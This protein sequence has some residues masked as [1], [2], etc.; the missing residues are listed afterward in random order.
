MNPY[1]D[2]ATGKKLAGANFGGEIGS[3]G[4]PDGN[5]NP[6]RQYQAVEFEINKGLGRNWAIV[7]NY[8]IARLIGNYEGA[9]RNDNG[10][11]DPGISSLF[12]FTPGKLNMLGK[13]MA[14]GP[15][16]TDRRHVLNV[17]PTVI[18]P[19]GMFKNLVLGSR[20]NIQSGVPLM[21]LAANMAYTNQGEAVPFGRGD[22]GRAPV[23]GTVDAHVE[24]PWKM[25]ENKKLKFGIDFFNIANTKRALLENQ[26]VDLAFGVPNKDFQKPGNG[27]GHGYPSTLVGG[28]VNPFSTR[29]TVKF[30]F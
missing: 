8:R 10:Q 4:I 19:S 3:D 16:N 11:G 21:T 15:L 6:I 2:P 29:A 9:Y 27:T 17:A 18:I 25:A 13:L 26:F 28:F 5:A 7:A 20:V 24:Y 1:I 14:I 30:E 23:T 22:L 12:D